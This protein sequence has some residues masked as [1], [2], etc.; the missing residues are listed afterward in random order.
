MENFLCDSLLSRSNNLLKGQV[1]LVIGASSGIDE[2]IEK[3][4]SRALSQH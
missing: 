1:A 2:Y 4:F 3:A